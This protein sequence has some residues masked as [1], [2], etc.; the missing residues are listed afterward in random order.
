[1]SY[2]MPVWRPGGE[3]G[4]HLLSLDVQRVYPRTRETPMGVTRPTRVIG[5]FTAQLEA[6][7]IPVWRGIEARATQRGVGVVGFL[8]RRVD[9]PIPIEAASNIVYGL[10]QPGIVDGLIVAT[11]T[12][13]TFLDGE[14]ISRFFSARS[15]IPKVS[16]GLKVP[17]I[18]SVTVDGSAGVTEV[19][20]HLIRDHGVR[21][22]ALIGG[23]AGHTE[24]EERARAFRQALADER[25]SFDESLA[26]H[27]TFLR[28]SGEEAARAVIAR[29]KPF[30]ALVCMNDRMALGAIDALRAVGIKV[31]E[32]VA[33]VGFDGIEEARYLSPP[34]TTVMQ[35]LSELEARPLTSFWMRWTERS[36]GTASCLASPSCGNP[37][38]VPHDAPTIR[39]SAAFHPRP[40]KRS[41]PLSRTWRGLRGLPTL[42]VSW[43]DSTRRSPRAR[44]SMRQA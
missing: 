15:H 38:D 24:A 23:P 10:A 39:A 7:Q 8:G 25:V 11:N 27:G 29:G 36:P 16:V 19:V 18:P 44:P 2:T 21:R 30:R 33:V 22:F 3:V 4:L 20:R 9:A 37:A 35:P 14:G 43:R 32:D 13:A 31:P 6:Y 34:L 40:P 26:V 1:M 42:T 12:I 17:G 41:A 5:F 28:E